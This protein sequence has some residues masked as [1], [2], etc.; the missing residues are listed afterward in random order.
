M[1]FILSKFL[2]NYYHY[3]NDDNQKN[4]D[5]ILSRIYGLYKI[6]FTGGDTMNLI[7]MKNIYCNFHIDNIITKYDLK[8]SKKIEK[9][10]LKMK[11][12]IKTK[13]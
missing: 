13:F 6:N 1:E 2:K 3:L 10:Q 9:L 8:G 7:L 4:N 12:I 5:S 11:K